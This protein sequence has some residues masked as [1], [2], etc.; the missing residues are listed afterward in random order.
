MYVTPQFPGQIWDGDTDNPWRDGRGNSLTP[1]ARDWDHIVAEVIATQQQVKNLMEIG[2]GGSSNPNAKIGWFLCPD[3]I[4]IYQVT[5]VGFK[6][7]RV[8]FYV[9]LAPGAQKHF[10][11]SMGLMDEFGNQNSMTWAAKKRSRGD[12]SVNRAIHTTNEKKIIVEASYVSMDGDGFTVDFLI[13][14]SFFIIR[15]DAIG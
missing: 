10:Y 13:V 9:S 14:N 11:C 15:W 3:A 4:G 8:T 12:S 7:K 6:P 1:N 2:G 5:G